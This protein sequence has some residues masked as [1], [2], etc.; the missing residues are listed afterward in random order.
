M[1]EGQ[2]MRD[3]RLCRRGSGSSNNKDTDW[4]GEKHEKIDKT[5]RL[6]YWWIFTPPIQVW[7]QGLWGVTAILKTWWRLHWVYRIPKLGPPWRAS[8]ISALSPSRI[9]SSIQSTNGVS[10][11]CSTWK[12]HGG[13]YL[14]AKNLIDT[15][16]KLPFWGAVPIGF[17]PQ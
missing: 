17:R 2:V 1:D 10:T 16:A 15:I 11:I 13:S 12:S 5:S 3:W 14:G 4:G 7:F 9:L 6:T 8:Y